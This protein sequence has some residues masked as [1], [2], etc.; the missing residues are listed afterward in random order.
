MHK[1]WIRTTNIYEVNL[2]QYTPDGT[3]GAFLPHL[4]RLKDMGV[5]TLWFMP[6]TPIAQKNKKGSLGSYYACS[7]YTSVDPEFG[8]I[9][10][11]KHLVKT[12]QAQG[13]RVILDWVANHT[14]W[15]HTWTE[16]HPE[17][18]LKDESGDFKKASG[19]DDIIELDYDNPDMRKAMISAMAFWVNETGIDGFRCDLADWVVVDFWHEAKAEMDKI[20]PLFWLAELD[21]LQSPEYM[22]V[23]DSAY[24]W[25]WMHK[26]REFYH[27]NAPFA[28]LEPTLK[29]YLDAKGMMAWFTT[30]HDEN[31]W[32]GTE[33][34]KYGDM[35]LLLAV[36]SCTWQGVPLMYNGQ[37]L[38][39]RKRLEF[40][41]KDPI[42][43]KDTCEL[44]GFY[45]TLLTLHS[46]HP[47]LHADVAPQRI[48]ASDPN[49]LAFVRRHGDSE[50]LAIM[51]FSRNPARFHLTEGLAKGRY[52]NIF[53]G[54]GHDF[55]RSLHF[56]MRPWEYWVYVK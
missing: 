35:A 3:I 4:P 53:S 1:D 18:Y 36:F 25:E 6:I 46:S 10:D 27:S 41:E 31:S 55:S 39:N 21:P 16:E 45:K 54:G 11:W 5:E 17:W 34:E 8:T 38:P 29:K 49:V 52:R 2:R 12:A 33:Y 28:V 9:D 14:G 43:W 56:E 24:T 40:F 22:D 13:F 23:F 26:T 51:N 30:N 37:E 48:P 32:N 20:R 19:M 50:V 15:D 42:E 44:H 47:A 7:D